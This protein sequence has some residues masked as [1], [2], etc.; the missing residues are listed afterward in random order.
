MI[1]FI[2][3]FKGGHELDQWFEH[4]TEQISLAQDEDAAGK[5]LE[6]LTK[7]AGF[8]GFTYLN[9]KSSTHTAISNVSY[10]WQDRYHEKSYIKLDPVMA[11]LR[12]RGSAF[13][14]TSPTG[15]IAKDV[16]NFFGEAAEFGIR[17]GVTIPILPGFGQVALLTLTSEEADFAE[18]RQL[19]PLRAAAAIGQ[20]HARLD[21]MRM[22]PKLQIPVRLKAEELTCLRWSSEGKSFKDIA[23][24]ENLSYSTVAFHINNAKQA[25][26]AMSLSQ[27]TRIGT[28]L[29]LF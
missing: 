2:T 29:R 10:E 12:S 14:W 9:L 13:A 28:E 4:L 16:R 11:G 22:I 5:V 25:L 6:K 17:S 15:R 1:A 19:D 7:E 27:A 8:S 23:Q 3:S 24:I 26:G 18:S 21:M 20:L